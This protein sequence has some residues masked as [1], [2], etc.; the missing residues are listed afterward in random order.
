VAEKLAK[1]VMDR[2]DGLVFDAGSLNAWCE[3]PDEI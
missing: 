1:A 3:L 2:A